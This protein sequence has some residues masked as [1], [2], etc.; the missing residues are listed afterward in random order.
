MKRQNNEDKLT[1]KD[2]LINRSQ[3]ESKMLMIMTKIHVQLKLINRWLI[4]ETV[5]A[6]QLTFNQSLY[7]VS[8]NFKHECTS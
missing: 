4:N 1:V 7:D 6:N 2:A 8:R 5:Y 3:A